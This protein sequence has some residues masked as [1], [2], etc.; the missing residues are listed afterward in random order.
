MHE[1]YERKDT[2]FGIFGTKIPHSAAVMRST[3]RYLL[4]FATTTPSKEYQT[5]LMP[6]LLLVDMKEYVFV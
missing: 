5:K 6:H 3:H 4:G 2:S 1:F